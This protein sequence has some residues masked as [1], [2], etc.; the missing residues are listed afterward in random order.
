MKVNLLNGYYIEIDSMNYTLMRNYVG[1]DRD[2]NPKEYVKVCGYFTTLGGAIYKFLKLNQ[3]DLNAET[4]MEMDEYVKRV[5]E[6]NRMAVEA[7][8]RVLEGAYG[9]DIDRKSH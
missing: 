5:E 8:K 9:Q 7:I 2:G 4:V 6:N 3:D 1:K